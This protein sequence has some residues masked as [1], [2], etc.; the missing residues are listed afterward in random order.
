MWYYVVK[1]GIY[2]GVFKAIKE[3]NSYLAFN[4]FTITK[5]YQKSKIET[6]VEVEVEW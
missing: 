6:I 3:L 1:D 5:I 4:H 2:L